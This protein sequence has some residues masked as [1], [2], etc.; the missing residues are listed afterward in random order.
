MDVVDA[1]MIQWFNNARDKTG[2]RSQMA[3]V[4][5]RQ[6]QSRIRLLRDYNWVD[7]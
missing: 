3:S 2:R 1:L 6:P 4:N 7:G 5:C